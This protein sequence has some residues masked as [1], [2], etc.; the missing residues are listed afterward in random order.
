MTS[1]II[2]ARFCWFI[3]VQLIYLSRSKVSCTLADNQLTFSCLCS[4]MWGLVTEGFVT[5]KKNCFQSAIVSRFR[6]FEIIF[7]SRDYKRVLGEE[8]P[9]AGLRHHNDDEMILIAHIN[10]TYVIKDMYFL[11]ILGRVL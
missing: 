1:N 3:G 8:G 5:N 11:I 9:R 6:P 10:C 4:N 2:V 7:F